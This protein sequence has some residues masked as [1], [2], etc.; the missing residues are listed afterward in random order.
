VVEIIECPSRGG[1]ARGIITKV[2]SKHGDPGLDKQSIIHQ[3]QLP[4]E[5]PAAVTKQAGHGVKSDSQV[6]QAMNHGEQLLRDSNRTT[7][8]LRPRVKSI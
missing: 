4:T 1:D 3:Y 6:T 7:G 5:S 8:S 2:L